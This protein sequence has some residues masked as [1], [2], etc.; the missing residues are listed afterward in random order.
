MPVNCKNYIQDYEQESLHFG[1]LE[2]RYNLAQGV[3][4]VCMTFPNNI[5]PYPRTKG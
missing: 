5:P 4:L 2:G 1:A 3:S